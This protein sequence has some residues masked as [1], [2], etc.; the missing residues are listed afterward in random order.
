MIFN[1]VLLCAFALL[2]VH[3]TQGQNLVKDVCKP[4]NKVDDDLLITIRQLQTECKANQQDLQHQLNKLQ[5]QFSSYQTDTHEEL[6]KLKAMV[7]TTPG[8]SFIYTFKACFK[9]HQ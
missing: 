1:I 7:P 2:H 3:T 9:R 5:D 6:L 8:T 4:R